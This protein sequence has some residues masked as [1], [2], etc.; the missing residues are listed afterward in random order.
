MQ[1]GGGSLFKE[2]REDEDK[3]Q[4]KKQERHTYQ[5]MILMRPTQTIHLWY[6]VLVESAIR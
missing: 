3:K 2:E 6:P 5:T 4:Q 1:A